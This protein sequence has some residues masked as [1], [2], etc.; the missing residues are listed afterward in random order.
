MPGE[1]ETHPDFAPRGETAGGLHFQ[2]TPR[3][4]LSE[5]IAVNG[6]TLDLNWKPDRY[7]WQSAADS[8]QKEM[9]DR[10]NQS[11]PFNRLHQEIVGARAKCS[12]GFVGAIRWNHHED[13]EKAETL[14]LTQLLC[15][16]GAVHSGEVE[17]A[18]QEIG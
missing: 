10:P 12:S 5:A 17:S 15:E 18:D 6:R 16:L 8:V 13:R 14:R 2:S 9:M 3:E 1:L 7:P 11:R 4:I